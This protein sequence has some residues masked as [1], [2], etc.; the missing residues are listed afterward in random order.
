MAIRLR[1]ARRT[2]ADA[3]SELAVRSKAHWGYPREWLELW[4]D[5]LSFDATKIDRWEVLV[6]EDEGQTVGVVALSQEGEQSEIE[7]FWV[8]PDAM[9]RGVGRTLFEGAREAAE[10]MNA[11]SIYVI[12]DPNAKPFYLRM[13]CVP[14][15]SVPS[16]PAGRSL[17]TLRLR[18]S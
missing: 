4:T 1:K 17:P 3:L 8:D 7:H 6:A 10:Q 9:G 5:D 12:S 11:T 13:G 15:G 18:L 14:E 2:E 16:E